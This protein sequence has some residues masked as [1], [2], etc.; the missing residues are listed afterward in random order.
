MSEGASEKAAGENRPG[1]HPDS[2]SA[3]SPPAGPWE[4]FRKSDTGPWIAYGWARLG[5][6][7]ARLVPESLAPPIIALLKSGYGR[8]SKRRMLMMRR[9]LEMVA[10]P[11]AEREIEVRMERAM[12]LY[13]R[14]W[15]ET[16]RLPSRPVEEILASIETEGEEL[17][18]KSLE[19]GK[20]VILALPHL[21][22]WD[23]AGCYISHKYSPVLAVAEYLRP[24]AAFEHWKHIRERLGMRIVPLDGTSAPVREAI[25]HLRGGGIVALVADRLIGTGGVEVEF[26]GE[27]TRVPAGP[28]TLARRTGADLM[29]VGLYM[30]D[31]GRHLGILRPS[32]MLFGGGDF[33]EDVARATQMLVR[34]FESLI[35]RDPEQWHLFTPFWPSDWR[36][37]GMEPPH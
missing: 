1:S 12:A 7:L 2:I 5:E 9:H 22:N 10:G 34:E 11:F 32:S 28:A 36:A 24:A 27:V 8:F 15:Y 6:T 30:L 25:K 23:V 19:R 21:G 3:G 29:P 37:L 33:Q 4:R 13:A 31:R 17:I 20:G 18:Q 35:R 26:F 16:F 14:Y